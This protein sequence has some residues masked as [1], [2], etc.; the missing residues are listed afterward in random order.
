MGGGENPTYSLIFLEMFLYLF[1][2]FFISTYTYMGLVV[3]TQCKGLQE[4]WMNSNSNEIARFRKLHCCSELYL[5]TR[6]LLIVLHA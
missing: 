6:C 1:M 2:I 4:I 5:V 3:G